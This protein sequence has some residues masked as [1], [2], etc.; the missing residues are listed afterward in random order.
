LTP[1][2]SELNGIEIK[3][4]F[5]IGRGFPTDFGK[6][7]K[8]SFEG[9]ISNNSDISVTIVTCVDPHI[10]YLLKNISKNVFYI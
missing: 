7:K 2:W 3:F 5:K 6:K 9:A 10:I 1:Y 4:I 8:D